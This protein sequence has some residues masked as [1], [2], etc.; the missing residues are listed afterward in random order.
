[1]LHET[2]PKTPPT[3][4]GDSEQAAAPTVSTDAARQNDD[5]PRRMAD[6]IPALVWVLRPDTLEGYFNQPWLRFS[7]RDS[8]ESVRS[9][10]TGDVHPDDQEACLSAY[11]F[12]L[13]THAPF[14]IEHRLQ[15]HDGAWRWMRTTGMPWF[16]AAGRALAG[17]SVTSS[18]VTEQKQAAAERERV[19]EENQRL[20]RAL[21][22]AGRRRRAFL[23]SVLADQSGG[24]LV[25]C[26]TEADLPAPLVQPD[27]DVVPLQTSVALR[28]LRR[29]VQRATGRTVWDQERRSDFT[30]AAV[31][32]AMNA[33]VHGGGGEARLFF[34]QAASRLQVW[35]RDW[36]PGIPEESLYRATLERGYSTR[37][38]NLGYGLW[39]G[40]QMAG[41]IYL[42]TRGEGDAAGATI[43]LEQEASVEVHVGAVAA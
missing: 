37:P 12:G 22:E 29:R 11:L 33:L 21:Q 31:E 17:Y 20:L 19:M 16:D 32:A 9:G 39:L 40:V 5:L 18:D 36:G 6:A 25:L 30:I 10:W 2:T 41:R 28:Q 38:G 24:R 15:R 1:M 13:R 42:L 8:S 23:R 43:V 26:E 7:G 3:N 14:E 34:D 27:G 35:V 4:S